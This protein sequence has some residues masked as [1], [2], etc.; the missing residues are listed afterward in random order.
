[1]ANCNGLVSEIKTETERESVRVGLRVRGRLRVRLSEIE[2]I[3]IVLEFY[4]LK[5]DGVSYQAKP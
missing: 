1:M 2:K 5:F 4:E 3:Y